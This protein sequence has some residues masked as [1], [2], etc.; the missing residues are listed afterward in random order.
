M[1]LQPF[2]CELRSGST[3]RG[4]KTDKPARPILFFLHGNGLCGRIYEPF[5]AHFDEQFELILLDITGHGASDG[6]AKFP[7]WNRIA[8]QCAE[9]FEQCNAS[10]REAI[11]VGHS[12]GGILAILMAAAQPKM[13]GK[14]VLLD[15]ILFPRRML[16]I[17]TLMKWL[18]L[19]DRVH[20]MVKMTKKRRRRWSSVADA[21]SYFR[22]RGA[23]K[24]WHEQSIENYIEYGTRQ[25]EDGDIVLCCDP[26]LEAE[27]FATWPRKLWHSIGAVTNPAHILM[28]QNTFGF[29]LQAATSAQKLNAC[30]T[31]SRVD[32]DHFFMLEQPADTARRVLAALNR[33]AK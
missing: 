13:F 27:I 22:T 3:L 10:G 26:A 8:E 19:T 16:L 17:F 23:F 14:L 7:G 29:A 30:I 28:G 5:L 11:I 15:P 24:K 21:L 4:W 2:Q 18:H 1:N 31:T 20:P 32:G 9:A 25:A 12:F 33:L 6:V